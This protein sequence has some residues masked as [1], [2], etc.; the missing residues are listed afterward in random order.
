M[1][2]GGILIK[3]AKR[4]N[5]E[6]CLGDYDSLSILGGEA[7]CKI[8]E[9]LNPLNIIDVP[10][11]VSLNKDGLLLICGGSINAQRYQIGLF[12]VPDLDA[13]ICETVIVT[14]NTC[15]NNHA[16]ELNIFPIVLEGNLS[17]REC[18]TLNRVLVNVLCVLDAV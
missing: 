7:A 9:S 14:R 10:L 5:F 17:L 13:I 2:R 8:A 1:S 6:S 3:G 12:V 15:L 16:I 4:E 11:K 18:R